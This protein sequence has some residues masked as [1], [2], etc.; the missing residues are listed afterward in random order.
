MG[1]QDYQESCTGLRGMEKK[2][3]ILLIEEKT[4]D[5]TSAEKIN[6]M[7]DRFVYSDVCSIFRGPTR[8]GH[9]F[10]ESYFIIPT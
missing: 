2:R 8:H 7:D 4:K 10:L 1:Y 5:R 6:G 9:I 3:T